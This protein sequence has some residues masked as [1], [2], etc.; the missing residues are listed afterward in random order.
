MSTDMSYPDWHQAENFL[1]VYGSLLNADSRLRFGHDPH[2]VGQEAVSI[3]NN[4]PL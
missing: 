2:Q 1:L 4:N 3:L